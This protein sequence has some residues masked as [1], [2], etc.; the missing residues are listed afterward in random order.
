MLEK[1]SRVETE[2]ER[3]LF[4]Y[5]GEQRVM[6]NYEKR[7]YSGSRYAVQKKKERKKKRKKKE[8]RSPVTEPSKGFSKRGK[9]R[10]RRNFIR[11]Y[12]RSRVFESADEL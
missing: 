6:L 1:G 10:A 5:K 3:P 11:L 8:H 7:R 12:M 9:K 4:D 2:G